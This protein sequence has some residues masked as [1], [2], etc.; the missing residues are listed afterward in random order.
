MH[1]NPS[2]TSPSA[3]PI[4]CPRPLLPCTVHTLHLLH[5]I[6]VFSSSFETI[7]VADVVTTKLPRAATP[8][9]QRSCQQCSASAAGVHVHEAGANCYSQDDKGRKNG[10]DANDGQRILHGGSTSGGAVRCQQVGLPLCR[11]LHRRAAG[12]ITLKGLSPLRSAADVQYLHVQAPFT[13]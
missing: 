10:K 6:Y 11:R 5:P 13:R 4:L 8:G 3:F 9:S 12:Q 7:C 2:N 1:N